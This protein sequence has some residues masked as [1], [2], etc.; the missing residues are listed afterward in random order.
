M[1]F[2]GVI[3]SLMAPLLA[4]NPPSSHVEQHRRQFA[5]FRKRLAANPGDAL[6]FAREA[7]GDTVRLWRDD[8]RRG[9]AL[10]M[11]CLALM[12]TGDID[13]MLPYAAEV[14][15]IRRA[16]QPSEPELEALALGSYAVAL[17]GANRAEETDRA[18]R[19]QLDAYRRAFAPNDL[20]LAQKLELHAESVQNNFGRKAW[21]IDLLQEAVAI[22][23][24]H[25]E[26]SPGKLAET[27]EQLTLYQLQRGEISGAEANLKRAQALLEKEIQHNPPR[28]ENKAGLAQL[29]VLR[30]GLAGKLAQLDKALSLAGQA[31]RI[32]FRD[33]V[34]RAENEL[35]VAASLSVTFENM[36]DLSRALAEQNKEVDVFRRHY[37]LLEKGSL[38]PNLLG[39]VYVS[40]A[41]LQAKLRNIEEAHNDA[42]LARA[43]LGGT[44]EVLFAEADIAQEAGDAATAVH[45]YR[46]ALRVRKESIAEVTVF[47]GTNRNSDRAPHGQF[48]FG[49]QVVPEITLGRASVLVPGA[50]FNEAVW[51]KRKRAPIIPVG[52]ATSAE[53]LLIREQ[54]SFDQTALAPA[55]RAVLDRARL[56]PNSALVF[57]HGYRVSFEAAVQR[58]AQ[59]VRDLNYDGPAFVFS[60]PSQ[61][62]LLLY[63]TDRTIADK[64]VESLAHFLQQVQQ[65]TGNA[66]VHIMAHS[67]GNRVMLPALASASSSA[68]RPKIGEVILA[69][70]AVPQA[71]CALWF[72]QLRRQGLSRF[73]LY[74]SKVDLA[75][76]AALAL[77]ENTL[78]AGHSRNGGP[79]LH[80]GLDSVDI[81]EAGLTFDIN[82]DV[83]A[84]NP[85]MVEDMRQL[86]QKGIRP[87][88]RRLP[89]LE[90]RG[91]YW[92]YHEP[93]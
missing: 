53:K 68:V 38:D 16:T 18:L 52:S 60:W 71:E 44:A 76:W 85:V 40:R 81:S 62:R 72:D 63:S 9:D 30:S 70:P 33:P 7:L 82:H 51:L 54:K 27:L 93:R 80:A 14:V 19:D 17:F 47:F 12:K 10:E 25:P 61:N 3:V 74:A 37:D 32:S 26:S 77:T 34:L 29:L 88:D 21:A 2:L 48:R 79:F 13:S 58:V 91:G 73:T 6:I 23:L 90:P 86:L 5:E 56:Y 8:P 46:E 64:S 43:I 41:Q 84:S 11:L 45:R 69:A 65:I 49:G 36:G 22:R 20:Q 15:R 42:G 50:Q 57:V 66:K 83:F 75:M 67:M 24:A 87:P 78:L 28:E 4:Q 39:D 31:R 55:V 35:G 89:T 92:Y 59:L 1:R